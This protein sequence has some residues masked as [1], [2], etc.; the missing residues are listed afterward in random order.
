MLEEG[1][2]LLSQ[3]V[4]G[5]L[6]MVTSHPPPSR[7]ILLHSATFP[8][9]VETFRKKHMN[10]P[11]EINLRNELTRKGSTQYY[12]SIQERQKGH[13]LNTLF[14]QSIIV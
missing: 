1:D 6:E 7:Q 11:Y 13:C 2:N 4:K 5:G 9:T 3:D 8:L 14:S 12:V 10:D